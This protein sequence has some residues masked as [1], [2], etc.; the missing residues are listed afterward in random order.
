MSNSA[1]LGCRTKVGRRRFIRHCAAVTTGAS[2]G[3]WIVSAD[4]LASSG[5]LNILMWSGYL[6]PGF[7]KSFKAKTGIDIN[8]TIIRSNEDILDRM[9]VTGGK[10]F[11]MVSPTSMRSLQWSSLNLLQPFDYTRIKNLSNIHDQ[12]LAIGDAEWNFDNNGSHWLPHIWGSEG[13]AWR[14]DKWTPPRDGEIPSFGD[15]WQPDMTGKVMIRPHSGMLGVGLFLE[16]TGA[17][18]SGAMREAYADEAKMRKTWA[19]VT[20]FCVKNKGQVKLFWNDA[21][22]QRVALMSEGVVMGQLWESPPINLMRNGEPVQYRAPLEGPLVWVDGMSLSARAENV[23]AAYNF[24]DYCFELEPAGK[25][26]DGG[27]EGQLWGGHGYN[28]AV[29]G[30]ERYAS[31]RYAKE[32]ASIYSRSPQ[33]KLW[34]WPQEPYWYAGVRS[35]YTNRFV[36]A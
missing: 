16:T 20:D 15:L 36:Y 27:S 13:I 22:K 11:D 33:V 32:F 5:Q 29:A 1:K 10:G 17:L 24:I 30:A 34:I 2:V 28:S 19:V 4:V 25:S 8:H 31:E 26:I 6:P 9:K 21:D 14:T 35:E 12:L 23:E 3:P 18:P 7:I